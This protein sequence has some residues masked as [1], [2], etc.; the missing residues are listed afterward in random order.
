VAP[1]ARWDWQRRMRA[2]P[3]KHLVYRWVVG[4]LGVLIVVL[5]LLTGPIPGPGGIPLVLLGLAVLASEFAW[6]RRLL[7]R[8][9]REVRSF[10]EWTARQP[11]WVRGAGTAGL[12]VLGVAGVWV[13]LAVFGPPSILPSSVSGFLVDLP[14]VER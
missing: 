3:K 12:L 11:R 10:T 5:G 9:K 4:V 6:A 14:G 8:V 1:R 2:D 13:A 7:D